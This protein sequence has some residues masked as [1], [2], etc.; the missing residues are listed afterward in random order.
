MKKDLMD[1]LGQ[2]D[3]AEL[4]KLADNRMYEDKSEYYKKSGKDRRTRTF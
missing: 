1:M 4:E 2:P 3:E